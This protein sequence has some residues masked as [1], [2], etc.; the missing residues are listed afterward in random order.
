VVELLSTAVAASA[1]SL[2]WGTLAVLSDNDTQVLVS[3]VGAITSV[4]TAYLA[5]KGNQRAKENQ[6]LLKAPRDISTDSENGVRVEA[7]R[8][9][10]V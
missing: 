3:M 5:Y 10:D 8:E 4:A 1:S 9:N 2:A 7:P 6:Q